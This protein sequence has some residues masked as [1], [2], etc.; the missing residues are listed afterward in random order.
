MNAFVP[1]PQKT[2][3]SDWDSKEA[4]LHLWRGQCID[5]Y[6]KAEHQISK[7]LLVLAQHSPKSID[8]RQ[9]Y[10]FGQKIALLRAALESDNLIC[11]KG[12]RP[13]L[14]ALEHFQQYADLRSSVCH[15]AA[16]VFTSRDGRW[17]AELRTINLSAAEIRT[18]QMMLDGQAMEDMLKSI[19][20]ASQSLNARL[21]NL[22]SLLVPVA[23]ANPSAPVA[24]GSR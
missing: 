5:C 17:L 6:T 12:V 19:W 7:T 14:H 24:P 4:E 2:A 10:L 8:L 22:C 9:G 15:G 3:R 23:E 11:K 21:A 13:A 16:T 1:V 18:S 20:S